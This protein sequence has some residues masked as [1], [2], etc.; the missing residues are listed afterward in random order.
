MSVSFMSLTIAKKSAAQEALVL[1]S[2]MWSGCCWTWK[3]LDWR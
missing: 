1:W 3:A 2:D